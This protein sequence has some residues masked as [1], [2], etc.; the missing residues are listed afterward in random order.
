MQENYE[1]LGLSPDASDEDV[2]IAYRKLKEKYSEERFCEG[3]KG[4]IAARKLSQIQV[5]YKEIMNERNNSKDSSSGKSYDYTEVEDL[6]KKGDI[7]GA[8]NLLDNIY[9]RDGEWHYLQSVIFYKKNWY[10]ESKKQLE[11]AINLEPNN[12]KYNDAYTKLKVKM[13]F[14]EKQFHSGNANYQNDGVNNSRQMGGTNSNECCTFC[15][16]WCC[17]DMLCSICCR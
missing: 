7:S 5:A 9:N 12:A 16:T 14:N 8:Q 4:N 17:M 10:N 3:E 13:D 6:I 15:A 2:E 1:I 11:I